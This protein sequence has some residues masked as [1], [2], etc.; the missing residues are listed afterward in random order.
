MLSSSKFVE[1]NGCF[2][3][4]H[5]WGRGTLV[6]TNGDKYIGEVVPDYVEGEGT[7]YRAN[8]EMIYGIWSKNVL[9]YRY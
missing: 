3:A 9:K 6:Y 2:K 8:G 1:Y 4:G 5:F 7:F